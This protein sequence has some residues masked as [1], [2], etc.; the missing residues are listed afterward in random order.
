MAW[1]QGSIAGLPPPPPPRRFSRGIICALL[2]SFG[3]ASP[4]W[5]QTEAETEANKT[6]EEAEAITLDAVVVTGTRY[7]SEVSV[8]GKEPLRPREIP[9]SVSVITKERIEDQGLTTLSDALRQVPGVVVTPVDATQGQYYSRGYQLNASYDGVS[10]PGIFSGWQQLDLAIY[11]Q[12]EVLRGPN[13]LLQGPAGQDFGGTVNLARKRGQKKFAASGSVSAG[14]WNNYNTTADV[15]GPLNADGSLRARVVA[16]VTDREYFYDATDTKKWLGYATLEW[17]V[18]PATS[19]S[20]ALARQEDDTDAPFSGLPAHGASPYGLLDVSRSTNVVADWGEYQ[21]ETQDLF[22]EA[23]HRFND[24]WKAVIKFNQREQDLYINDGYPGSGVTASQT[25]NYY[26]RRVANRY[27]S[28]ALDIYVSGAF[29]LW[30][31]KHQTTLGYNES[32]V[33][34]SYKS[35]YNYA[36]TGIPFG[37]PDLVQKFD[38]PYVQSGASETSQSGFYGQIRLRVLDPL[39]LIAGARSSNYR[40]RNRPNNLFTNPPVAWETNDDKVK[41]EVT[42]YGGLVFDVNREIS[43]YASYADVFIPQAYQKVGGGFLEPR[44]G[45]QYEIGGKGEFFDGKLTA[46]LAIFNLRDKNR[47]IYD[48]TDGTNYYYLNAGEVESK[49]WEMEVT[50]SP[51]PGWD[52]SASYSRL[53]TK[54][55]DDAANKGL[56]YV[57]WFPKHIFR[58][59]GVHRFANGFSAGLGVNAASEQI[60]GTAGSGRTRSQ[61][62]YAVADAFLSYRINKNF[63]AQLNVNNIF[64]KTYYAKLGALAS[65]NFYGEP[66]NFLLTLRATY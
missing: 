42:P 12:V 16:S 24:D 43:L 61:S 29:S 17:D 50:G 5:A 56:P 32:E 10:A 53:D 55:L 14:S 22:A 7:T 49:G 31:R 46:S 19:F 20:I 57:A 41:G 1:K 33:R 8:G 60:S 39:T 2:A 21:W 28:D 26:R 3:A 36:A 62:G 6:E 25:L 4:A 44:V 30:G 35:V 64:D 11:D 48:S 34:T 63:T 54:Y 9:Q 27:E 18:T 38:A 65:G 58:L 52:V 13:G 45:K 23:T 51:A 47:P 40:S 15:G 66:R 37:R 59:W